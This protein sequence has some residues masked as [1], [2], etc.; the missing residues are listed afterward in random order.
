MRFQPKVDQVLAVGKDR[1]EIEPHPMVPH[2]P[3]GQE[4]RM[5]TVYKMRSDGKNFALKVFKDAYR[6][7]E[8]LALSEK[9]KNYA[10]IPGLEACQRIVINPVELKTLIK[11]DNDLNF[12]VIMPWIEGQT[13]FDILTGKTPLD[14][15]Q[16]ERLAREFCRTMVSMEERSVSHCDLSA[17]NVILT[18]LDTVPKISLVDVEQ[19]FGPTLEQPDMLLVGTPGY[20]TDF[21]RSGFWSRFSDRFAGAIL[22]AEMLCWHS[23]AVRAAS[24]GD[25]YFDPVELQQVVP[26]EA[27]SGEPIAEL[28]DR[29]WKADSFETCPSFWEWNR[30]LSGESDTVAMRRTMKANPVIMALTAF[31]TRAR[32]RMLSGELSEAM[33]EY[34]AALAYAVEHDVSPDNYIER[35]N[36]LSLQQIAGYWIEDRLHERAFDIVDLQTYDPSQVSGKKLGGFKLWQLLVFIGLLAGMGFM[37]FSSWGDEIRS[38]DWYDLLGLQIGLAAVMYAGIRKPWLSSLLYLVVA[39]VVGFTLSQARPSI[40]APHEIAIQV[41]LS[42]VLLE[43]LLRLGDW[44]IRDPIRRWYLDL[45]WVAGSAFVSGGYLELQMGANRFDSWPKVGLNF[46]LALAGWLLGKWLESV[47]ITLRERT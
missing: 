23:E 47:I 31:E 10:V 33:T 12:A 7:P 42:A 35:I 26:V 16:C 14:K 25:S 18:N 46:G 8:I 20:I 24:W 30:I 34:E 9:L 32:D 1:Y 21:D 40:L 6:K 29:V 27:G 39:L 44:M 45:A 2:L 43:L 38:S 17:P 3:Y 13:W 4:G 22:L 28:F 36:E 11:S 41:V 15:E 19:L 5:A 37:V